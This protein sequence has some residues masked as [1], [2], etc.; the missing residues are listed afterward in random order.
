FGKKASWYSRLLLLAASI[1]LMMADVT[2]D[3][4]ALG[5]VLI[6]ILIQTVTARTEAVSR[7]TGQEK[8]VK[9]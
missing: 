6:V 1:M 5:F 4:I 3:F 7:V 9:M 8:K 2:S